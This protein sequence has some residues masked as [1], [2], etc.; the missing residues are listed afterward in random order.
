MSLANE[1]ALMYTNDNQDVVLGL[2]RET[3]LVMNAKL[4]GSR[5]Q[6]GAQY[7]AFVRETL[8]RISPPLSNEE[9]GFSSDEGE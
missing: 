3:T 8:D 4:H 2:L 9:D 7:V 1:H 6:H 5:K